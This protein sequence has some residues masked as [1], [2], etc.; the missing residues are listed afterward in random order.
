MALDRAVLS[1]PGSAGRASGARMP[2]RQ[3]RAR[4]GPAP[5]TTAPTR[6]A[7]TLGRAAIALATL[8]A[9]VLVGAGP[10]HAATVTP[11]PP[12]AG[13][14]YQLAEAY[15]LPRG[16]TVVAR[17]RRSRRAA[18]AYNICYVNAFQAQPEEAAWWRRTH[19]HLLLKGRDGRYVVDGGWNE[20][21][22]D[23]STPAKRAA[24]AAIVGRWIDGC[25]A[26]GY[27]AVE[28]DNLDS[29]TR[30]GGRLT[31]AYALAYAR[32]LTARAHRRGLAIAQKNTVELGVAGRAAGFDFAVAEACG[33][34][35]E[36]RDYVRVYGSRVIVVE[37]RRVDFVRTCRAWGARLSVVLRD[38]AVSAPGSA[39]YLRQA[40]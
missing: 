21:L 34:Y 20:I 36:C 6:A 11:P 19:P 18:G 22:L 25:R 16:V 17:D 29:W 37:Y 26:A 31:R 30:S 2:R 40:C 27:R 5:V 24:V 32:L 33:R 28:P 35:A 3:A 23:I 15:P 7:T 13:F 12:N 8:A 38:R 10:A 4:T 14:D 9:G 39:T 1:R